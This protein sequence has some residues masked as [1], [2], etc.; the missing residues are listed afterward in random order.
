[1]LALKATQLYADGRD[2]L[3]RGTT[4]RFKHGG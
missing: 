1:L 4:S 3:A 2:F